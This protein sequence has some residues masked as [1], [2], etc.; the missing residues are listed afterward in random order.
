MKIIWLVILY[1]NLTEKSHLHVYLKKHL[2]RNVCEKFGISTETKS[3]EVY[4]E[5]KFAPQYTSIS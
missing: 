1:T 2:P 5:G 3:C 4:K